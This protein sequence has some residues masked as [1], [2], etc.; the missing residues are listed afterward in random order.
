M[1]SSP[2][3]NNGRPWQRPLTRNEQF[4]VEVIRL[5]SHDSDP[6]PTLAK[7]QALRRLFWLPDAL[8]LDR[9]GGRT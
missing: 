1:S 3:L 4:W 5:A 8:D 9:L 2:R 6:A 7:V